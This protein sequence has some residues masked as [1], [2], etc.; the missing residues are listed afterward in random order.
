MATIFEQRKETA[1]IFTYAHFFG[2]RG[3]YPKDG[4]PALEKMERIIK[5]DTEM[6]KFYFKRLEKE[7]CRP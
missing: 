1:I 2:G 5:A 7:C 3:E 4:D 6:E